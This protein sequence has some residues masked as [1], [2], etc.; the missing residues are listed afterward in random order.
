MTSVALTTALTSSPSLRSSWSADVRLISAATSPPPTSPITPAITSPF[1]TERTLPESLLRA[2]STGAS[3]RGCWGSPVRYP[4]GPAPYS[5]ACGVLLPPH[6]LD[7][8]THRLLV[9]QGFEGK[10]VARD[11]VCDHHLV[12]EA[13]DQRVRD[14]GGYRCGQVHPVGREPRCQHRDRNHQP[15]QTADA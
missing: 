2:L 10:D 13:L 3:S 4:G 11:G 8:Q 6:L 9:A 12:L 15:T 1:L 14:S 5:S 7:G